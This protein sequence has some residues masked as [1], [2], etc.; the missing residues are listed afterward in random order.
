MADLVRTLIALVIPAMNFLLLF[1][2]GLDLTENDFARVRRQ[3]ALIALGLVAPL[4]LLPPI[5][6]GL[7]WLLQPGPAVAA[8]LLLIAACPIGG[9][10]NAF[11]YLARASTAL[12]VT[13]TGLSCV[14]ASV[15][16]PLVSKAFEI[17]LR[18]PFALSAPLSTLIG[19]LVVVLGLP[20]A[21]GMWLHRS[22]PGFAEKLG[23]ALRPLAFIG[24][25]IVLLLIVVDAPV[26][27]VGGLT[28]TVPLA[29]AFVVSSIVAGWIT[30]A[31]VT[32]D[33][34][35]RFALAA[36]FG[37][38]NVGIAMAIAVTILGRVEFASFAVIYSLTEIPL[39]LA[40]IA[41]FR[42]LRES[43]DVRREAQ[44]V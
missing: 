44:L 32:K 14:A 29:A 1:T 4:L 34:R 20:V 16:I 35:D 21:L 43:V 26:A 9:I 27:F 5:A 17:S 40:A 12:S 31:L 36:E 38:R 8:S 19:Q 33:R 24:T 10:S 23:P 42:R 41:L 13:L 28:R 18:Q 3:P 6:V 2:V 11:T 7:I 15:T 30:G 22:R 25:A 37:S 39:M